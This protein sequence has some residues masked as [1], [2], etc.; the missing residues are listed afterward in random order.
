M[1]GGGF[2]GDCQTRLA[3][4]FIR[5]LLPYFRGKCYAT[6]LLCGSTTTTTVHT[7]PASVFQASFWMSVSVLR[8]RINQ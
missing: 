2:P 7:N 5:K 6:T 3:A 4:G 1:G 8:I